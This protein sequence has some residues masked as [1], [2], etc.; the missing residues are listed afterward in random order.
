MRQ[1][2]HA[3]EKTFIDF[4]GSGLDVV[5]PLTGECQKAVLFLA[6]LGASNL[7]Y[8]EPVL[9]Q[10]LPTWVG[11]HLP[12]T[13]RPRPS[14]GLL[15][16]LTTPQAERLRRM[17]AGASD[18]KRGLQRHRGGPAGSP[19][20]RSSCRFPSPRPPDA[21]EAP[22]PLVRYVARH[23]G[24]PVQDSA[25]AFVADVERRYEEHPCCEGCTCGKLKEVAE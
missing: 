22:R 24:P 8:A 6:V 25:A 18:G 11:C 16:A 4:S 23:P 14:I 21:P 3:G 5:H 1:A 17:A 10:D 12:Q 9:Q 19:R 7:T 2:H 15:V 20:E 13:T